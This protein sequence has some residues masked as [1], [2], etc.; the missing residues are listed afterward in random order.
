MLRDT[1]L[2]AMVGTALRH[3]RASS[4]NNVLASSD[5]GVVNVEG[6]ATSVEMTEPDERGHLVH[7]N[8]YVCDAMLP[9]EGDPAYA[10]RSAVRYARAEELLAAQPDGTMTE[11]R[12]RE[13]L[14]DHE[15][16]PDSLCRHAEDGAPAR[17]RASGAS[18]TSPTCGS[19]SA[20]ATRATPSRRSSRSP[21]ELGR[22]R[23]LRASR[24]RAITSA[25]PLSSAMESTVAPSSFVAAGVGAVREQ[26]RHR[27]QVAVVR[28]R[29][30]RRPSAPLPRVRIRARDRAAAARRPRAGPRPPSSA[31]CPSSTRGPCA[32][33]SAPRSR[34]T[35]ALSDAAEERRE[36]QRGEAVGGV[37]GHRPTDRRRAARAGDRCRRATPLRTRRSSG[38]PESTASRSARSDRYRARITRRHAVLVA[39]RRERRLCGDHRTHLVRGSR[40]DRREESPRCFPCSSLRDSVM[41]IG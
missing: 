19:R 27:L 25:F 26:Q 8:H 29:V 22:Q 31:A 1:S 11:E 20:A 18:P 35:R 3:D 9:Y 28:G 24:T 14:S 41:C 17:S 32:S 10:R 33:T 37:R 13:I 4:Y 5:G 6:S 15:H 34:R 21:T 30:Q 39:R 12:M 2:D 38:S 23:A 40:L 36:V 16:A 7:T